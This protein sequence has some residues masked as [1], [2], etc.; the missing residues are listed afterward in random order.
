M[1]SPILAPTSMMGN[2]CQPQN[3]QFQIATG[4][5]NSPLSRPQSLGGDTTQF[6]GCP[7]CAAAATTAL[8]S[9][10]TGGVGAFL[11]L[12]KFMNY[13]GINTQSESF[14]SEPTLLTKGIRRFFESTGLK[15]LF[16]TTKP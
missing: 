2:C 9:G 11:A 10:G 15:E 16:T 5:N 3:T 12:K 7:F 6:Q 14:K 4:P 13:L 1:V 8:I